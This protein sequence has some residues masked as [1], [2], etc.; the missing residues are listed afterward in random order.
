MTKSSLSKVCAVGEVVD[1]ASGRVVCRKTDFLDMVLDVG[2]NGLADGSANGFSGMMVTC[3]I[4]SSNAAN[5]IGSGAV[6]FTQ[7]G[8]TITASAGFFTSA[9]TG[10]ILKYG[11]GS[12]GV[13]QYITYVSPTQATSATSYTQASAI[14]GTAWLVQQNSLVAYLYKNISYDTS[15]SGC[16]TTFAS[17]T[18]TLKRTF[19]F[20]NES[21]PYNVS[22]IGYSRNSNNDGTVDGRIVLGSPVTVTATQFYRVT[23]QMS[24]TVTPNGSTAAGNVG[25]GIDTAGN[26]GVLFWDCTIVNSDGTNG[27]AQTLFGGGGSNVLDSGG[28]AI[29]L[30][31]IVLTINPISASA[32]NTTG[33]YISA[34]SNFTNSGQPVGVGL[35]TI[36]Y[37]FNTA[38]ET[39]DGFNLGNAQGYLCFGQNFTAPITLPTGAFSGVVTVTRQFTRTLTN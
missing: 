12:A 23:L 8:N 2:L 21:S 37:L 5:S 38:G 16:D 35:A 15:G 10:G 31:G 14:V 11:S 7:S 28:V 22:E 25:T 33:L 13:E 39:C 29:A 36:N 32:S 18:I 6:T 24:W 3:K 30:L 27:S 4:G 34:Q 1:S 20:A 19:V 9:M 17:N 26:C